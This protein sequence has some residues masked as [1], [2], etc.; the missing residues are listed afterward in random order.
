[1]SNH[2]IKP[3]LIQKHGKLHEHGK[4]PCRQGTTLRKSNEQPSALGAQGLSP[5]WWLLPQHHTN[6]HVGSQPLANTHPQT[7]PKYVVSI[8][9]SKKRVFLHY[10]SNT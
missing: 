7:I 3:K 6:S 4:E 1:M 9:S 8:P 10:Q 5:S 2:Q